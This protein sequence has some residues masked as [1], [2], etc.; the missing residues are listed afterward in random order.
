MTICLAILAILIWSGAAQATTLQTLQDGADRLEALQNDDGGWDWPLDN[1]DPATSSP[2]NT[3][4][5]IAMGLGK[6]YLETSDADHLAALQGAATFLQAKTNNFSPSDGY[7]AVELDAILGGTANVDHVK[8][9]FYDKLAAG[10]YDRNG[11]GTLYTT[12]S[13]VQLIRDARASLGNLAAWDIGMGLYSAVAIGASTTE[14]IAGVEAELD[15]HDSTAWYDVLGLAGAIMGMASAGADY[16][17]T[18]GDLVAAS[19]LS[20]LADIL[21]G[22]QLSTGGFSW[23]SQALG[24]GNESLQ[25]TAYAQLALYE[26]DSVGYR[27][28]TIDAGTYMRVVQL[29]TG[30]WEN[31]LGDG[32]NNEL[33]GEALWGIATIPEPTTAVLLGLGLAAMGLLRRRQA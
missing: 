16:D 10:T 20:D 32:E 17:T 1:G 15:E 29:G 26:Q 31:Y 24:A 9:N 25:E 2:A 11:A 8:T 6:A 27:T 5:P 19:N 21:V 14:W 23:S 28:E 22:Y 18:A 4:G 13:Y 7:L 12:A 3:I 30:G 33:T